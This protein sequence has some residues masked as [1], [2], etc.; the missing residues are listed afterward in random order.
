MKRRTVDLERGCKLYSPN[1][2]PR[3]ANNNSTNPTT[4][5]LI[6][7]FAGVILASMRRLVTY[8]GSVE[9]PLYLIVATSIFEEGMLIP[10][11]MP[12]LK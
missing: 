5:E 3:L 9:I 12:L 6:P 7:W 1:P 10:L 11:T 4:L 2:H 8:V